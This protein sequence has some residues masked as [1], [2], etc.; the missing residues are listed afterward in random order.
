MKRMLCLLLALLLVVGMFPVQAL[1]SAPDA[2]GNLTGA[3]IETAL[4]EE[5]LIYSGTSSAEATPHTHSSDVCGGA[6]SFATPLTQDDLTVSHTLAEG[7]YFLTEDIPLSQALTVSGSVSLCLNG[8][9]LTGISTDY[10]IN[11]KSTAYV[12]T[13]FNL[14]DCTHDSGTI[15]GGKGGIYAQGTLNLYGGTISGCV[16]NP[17]IYVPSTYSA[18]PVFNGSYRCILN[19]YGGE[20]SG[21]T[22]GGIYGSSNSSIRI[23]G[24]LITGNSGEYFGDYAVTAGEYG[25]FTLSGGQ[26]TGNRYGGLYIGEVYDVTIS[27]DPVIT[28]NVWGGTTRNIYITEEF[29]NLLANRTRLSL[30]GLTSDASLGVTTELVPT[31]SEAVAFTNENDQDYSGCFFPDNPDYEIINTAENVLSLLKRHVHKFTGEAAEEAYFASAATCQS[32]EAYYYSCACGEKGTD[33]FFYGEKLAHT[34]AVAK[35][36]APTCTEPG[37]TEGKY[38]SVCGEILV[39]QETIEA[40]GHAEAIDKAVAAGCTATGLTEGKHCSVCGE[41][42]VAQEVV[43]AAGHTAKTIP[44]RAPACEE[45]GLTDGEVCVVCGDT[46][47][48]QEVLPAAG[49]Q[50]EKLPAAAPTCTEA[51]LTEGSRCA[52][53]QK[54]FAAQET[55]PALGH[56]EETL[57]AQAPTCSETG[58]TEGKKCSVC[59]TV[60]L[61]QKELP[62]LPHTEEVLPAKD[63]TCTESGLTEG[64]Q[65]TVCDTV[66]TEQNVLPATGHTEIVAIP[67]KA[68]ACGTPGHTEKIMCKTCD[69]VLKEMTRIPARNH[70][71]VC[72][73]CQVERTNQVS[74]TAALEQP[75]IPETS[76]AAAAAQ[77]G[78]SEAAPVTDAPEEIAPEPAEP[79]YD[80][81]LADVNAFLLTEPEEEE[82]FTLPEG[83]VLMLP[84]EEKSPAGPEAPMAVGDHEFWENEPNDWSWEADRIENDFTVYGNVTGFDIDNFAFYLS[85]TTNVSIQAAATYDSLYMCLYDSN[86]ELVTADR[87]KPHIVKATL[88]AGQYRLRLIDSNG[89]SNNYFFYVNFS[90]H[91]HAAATTKTVLPTCTEDGYIASVCSCGCIMS[92]IPY[93]YATGHREV[94]V[95]GKAATCTESGM[96]D[97]KKCSTCNK[98]LVAQT[99]IPAKGHV[100]N[101]VR[102]SKAPT[103][104]ASGVTERIKCK[105]CG[106]VLQEQETLPALGHRESQ[107]SAH[108]DPT[109]TAAGHTEKV[110]CTKCGTVLK[111]Q[112]NLPALGHDYRCTICGA[113]DPEAKLPDQIQRISGKDR[114]ETAFEIAYKL[115]EVLGIAEFDTILIASGENSADA[116]AGSYLAIRKQA[117]ILLS[118]GSSH[119]RNLAFIQANLSENG[120]VYILGGTSAVPQEMEDLLTQ[121]GIACQ[122]LKGPNRFDT[123]LAILAEAGIEGDEILVSTGYNFADSLSA[124]ASGKPMLLVNTS[125]NALTASQKE[126]LEGQRGKTFTIIGGTGA[127][128]EELEAALGE[129]GTVTRLKGS[130]REAT[131]VEVA[132]RYFASPSAALLAY[133]RNFPDGLCG[134]PL[135]YALGAPL[136]LVN[137]GQEAAARDYVNQNNI[138][139]GYIL[140]GTGVVSNETA[141]KVFRMEIG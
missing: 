4:A 130:G 11:L 132:K 127:V 113:K 23:Y 24:G 86:H 62:V 107:V 92:K 110:V 126:W 65:C 72:V 31:E 54:V 50:E 81:I 97:G 125:I 2:L 93:G 33:V 106:I 73:R 60:L 43:S 48:A 56:K 99:E 138:R 37:L 75:E 105:T 85:T 64:K 20:V 84:E 39:K 117:P 51:G 89:S 136:L 58:L 104:T 66:L 61:A 101:V 32:P 14:Y 15:T 116:L 131:S 120:L 17:G 100:E 90:A 76:A 53:C 134:G 91:T 47:L 141:R 102:P 74:V 49:H 30:D 124:S 103:C 112:T 6:C 7:T 79:G 69:A 52:V 38:C 26:I 122:R 29:S 41:V 22:H 55:V 67:Q 95:K 109:C 8:H 98:T 140:G 108:L 40:L 45:T 96:T 123:N 28:D 46:L 63:P 21:N 119:A 139:T 35:A 10:V 12:Q 44:G 34:E 70:D 1:A 111:K 135:A 88:P 5:T 114:H 129:Y 13:V 128:S 57:P 82:A 137:E 133:S 78:T 68:A 71:V 83:V 59:D 36:V 118:R 27:G 77:E 42:L 115:K 94:V 3:V 18:W 19:M 25:S 121:N 80:Q 16:K 9:T 87:G